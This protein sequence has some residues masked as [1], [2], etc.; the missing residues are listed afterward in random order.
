MLRERVDDRHPHAVQAAGETVGLVV[1]L[2]ARMESREDQFDAAYFFLRVYVDRHAA[3]V[4]D[5]ANGPIL[6]KGHV[7]LLAVSGDGFIDAVVDD[8]VRQ[9]IGPRGVGV[10]PR[11][12]AYRLK[13]C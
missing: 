6:V 12:T 5:H 10:H 3:A 2:A 13:A 9:V 1:E 11:S 4:V 7:D 8:L